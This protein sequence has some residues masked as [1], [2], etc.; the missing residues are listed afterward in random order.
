MLAYI[1][2]IT[3]RY[4]PYNVLTPEG[5]EVS[6]GDMVVIKHGSCLDHPLRLGLLQWI[7]GLSFLRQNVRQTGGCGIGIAGHSVRQ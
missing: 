1:Y 7:L 3:Y 4:Y 5:A 6:S 2:F